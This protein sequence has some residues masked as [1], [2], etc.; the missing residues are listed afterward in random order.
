M[1][2]ILGI[3][4]VILGFLAMSAPL[5]A[6]VVV[7]F[8]VGFFAIAGGVVQMVFAFKAPSFGR[9]VLRFLL[10]GLMLLGGLAIEA[11]PLMGLATMTL[12]LAMYFIA[13]GITRVVLAFDLRPEQ[14]WGWLVVGGLVSLVLGILLW[15]QWPLSGAWAVGVLVGVN[16]MISGWQLIILGPVLEKAAQELAAETVP[17]AST[18]GG[19]APAEPGAG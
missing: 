13:D 8:V 18:P 16:L 3:I 9:G 12:M 5:Y 2:V 7:I 19:T 15:R 10:G 1:G 4:Q 6:G 17:G 14:G 11:H